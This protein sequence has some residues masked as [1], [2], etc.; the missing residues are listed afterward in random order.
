MQF[1]WA[2]HRTN[3]PHPARTLQNKAQS[4]KTVK[5]ANKTGADG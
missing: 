1:L 3:H 4:K 5:N 2:P